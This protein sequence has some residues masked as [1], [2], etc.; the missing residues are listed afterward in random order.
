M[1]MTLV[2]ATGENRSA[3]RRASGSRSSTTSASAANPPSHTAIER[4]WSVSRG[5]ARRVQMPV[6]ACPAS[7]GVAAM[8]TPISVIGSHHHEGGRHVLRTIRSSGSARKSN[9]MRSSA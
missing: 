4:T 7:P 3:V 8:A 5:I 1:T 9:R 6:V 2:S